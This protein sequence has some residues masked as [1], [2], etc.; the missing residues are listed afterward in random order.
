[1]F[2]KTLTILL[3]STFS[4]SLDIIVDKTSSSN[5]LL[6][7]HSIIV[8]ESSKK[9]ARD[10]VLGLLRDNKREI[11]SDA[12]TSLIWQDNKNANSLQ[13]NWDDANTYCTSLVYARYS[14]WRLATISDLESILDFKKENP[15][16]KEGFVNTVSNNY[17]S[18][19]SHVLKSTSAWSV[20]FYSGSTNYFDKSRVAYI[21][22]VRDKK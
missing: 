21:R 18:S 13:K 7:A 9:I 12:S 15:A 20:N 22:C 3:I 10:I 17:W 6:D 16:I 2:K 14:D 5:F 8:K 1:M 11:I 4:Y 19:T